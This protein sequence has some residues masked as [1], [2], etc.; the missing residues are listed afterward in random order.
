MNE[1]KLMEDKRLRDQVSG[2][3]DVL[4]KVRNGQE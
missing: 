4:D 2:R 1:T 3:V